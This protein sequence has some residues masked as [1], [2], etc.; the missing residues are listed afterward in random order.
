MIMQPELITNEM[1]DEA[2][3]QIEIKKNQ[4]LYH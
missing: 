2:I 3:K 4:C 1:V